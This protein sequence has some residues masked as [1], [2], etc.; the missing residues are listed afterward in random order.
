MLHIVNRA[1]FDPQR[2]DRLLWRMAPGHTLILIENAVYMVNNGSV[3]ARRLQQCLSELTVCVLG[4][5]LAARGITPAEV[6]PGVN[7]VD[8]GG[9]VDLAVDNPVIQSCIS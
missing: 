6:L 1:V 8:Y 3:A 9:F 5:D 4:P 7:V 2:L